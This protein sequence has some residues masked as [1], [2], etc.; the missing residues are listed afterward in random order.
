MRALR[1]DPLEGVPMTERVPQVRPHAYRAS[2][3]YEVP[4]RHHALGCP[5]T[6]DRIGTTLGWTFALG[7]MVWLGW[8]FAAAMR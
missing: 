3:F 7:V 6:L 5:S 2:G 8:Q 4:C 1:E